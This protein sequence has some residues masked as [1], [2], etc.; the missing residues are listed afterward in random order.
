MEFTAN[1]C[2]VLRVARIRSINDKDYYL[3]GTKLDRV[4]FCFFFLLFK[5]IY[6]RNY[7][8]LIKRN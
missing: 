6:Y 8:E 4:F 1:K 3:G 7:K 2:K 5:D